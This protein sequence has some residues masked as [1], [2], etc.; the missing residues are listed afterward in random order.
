MPNPTSFFFVGSDRQA[1]PMAAL[2]VHAD[3]LAPAPGER[4]AAVGGD[5]EPPVPV[6]PDGQ[7][8]PGTLYPSSADPQVR[9]YLP[10]YAWSV[11]DGRYTTSLKWRSSTDDPNGPLAFLTLELAAPAPAAQGFTLQE[12]P[13]QAVVRFAFDLPVGGDAATGATLWIEAGAL[14]MA[15]TV[16][17]CRLPLATK[18]EFDRLYQVMT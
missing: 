13:H 9:F 5:A 7:L 1:M 14:E 16:R 12:I 4:P 2:L 6:S 17:R 10:Q 15:G 3:A 18:P 11:V 8:V